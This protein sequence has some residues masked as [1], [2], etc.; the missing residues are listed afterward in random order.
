MI[1]D[2]FNLNQ[3]QRIIQQLTVFSDLKNLIN[4]NC[5]IT[6]KTYKKNPN[7]HQKQL[8]IKLKIIFFPLLHIC[9]HVQ[10]INILQK[11]RKKEEAKKKK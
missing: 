10:S 7:K 5:N 2:C 4:L 1:N 8:E 3:T 9:S 11:K 6:S